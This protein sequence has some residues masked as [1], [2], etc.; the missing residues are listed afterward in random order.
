MALPTRRGGTGPERR[1]SPWGGWDP[2]GDFENT[3]SETGRPLE[4]PAVPSAI[5][6][7]AA[8]GEWMPMVE[9]AE[10]A[11]TGDGYA[12]R[13]ELPRIP[14]ELVDIAVE[15]HELHISGELTEERCGRTLDHGTGTFSYRT[16]LPSDADSEKI[17]ADLSDGVLTVRIPKSTEAKRRTTEAS[18]HR[19]IGGE[20]GTA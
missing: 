14:A 17:D 5:T 4:R 18:S 13:A 20:A 9:E 10:E 8:V 15:G 19:Q 11:E 16:S 1:M 2:L 7:G 3:R 6:A 12:I